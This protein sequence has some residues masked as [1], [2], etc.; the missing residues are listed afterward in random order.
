MFL[1]SLRFLN[2]IL[3]VEAKKL[4]FDVVLNAREEIV[5]NYIIME[6]VRFQT[7]KT[8]NSRSVI[9]Y[10]YVIQSLE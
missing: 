7:T 8:S 3:I 9:G 6:E 5:D 4:L 10:I 2:C 1:H